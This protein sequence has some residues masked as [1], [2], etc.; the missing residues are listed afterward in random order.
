MYPLYLYKAF[1]YIRVD[2]LY[3]VR[4]VKPCPRH[5]VTGKHSNRKK[6]Q[7]QKYFFTV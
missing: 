6:Q 5:I 7:Q 2:G 3:L 1:T 4:V